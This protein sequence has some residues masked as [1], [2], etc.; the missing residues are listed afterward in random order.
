[1]FAQSLN[2]LLIGATTNFK[3]PTRMDII[4]HLFVILMINK[5]FFYLLNLVSIFLVD[6]IFGCT[7]M[8]FVIL[9]SGKNWIYPQQMVLEYLYFGKMRNNIQLNPV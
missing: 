2:C 4:I 1:M 7:T 3:K 6:E 5:T 9:V 8:V